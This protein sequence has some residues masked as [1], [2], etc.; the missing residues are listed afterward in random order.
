MGL[1]YPD[2]ELRSHA[3][4]QLHSRFNLFLISGFVLR[5]RQDSLWTQCKHGVG[6][7][8]LIGVN[9]FSFSVHGEF[10]TETFVE[11][12]NDS[13]LAT[14]GITDMNFLNPLI[15]SI[16]NIQEVF[17]LVFNAR[18]VLFMRCT[19]YRYIYTCISYLPSIYR[20]TLTQG[21]KMGGSCVCS[22]IAFPISYK[23]FIFN[24]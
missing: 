19:Q 17:V 2:L 22:T 3:P 14:K 12:R 10:N 7:A 9:L 5:L 23:Y 16:G 20:W 8:T 24:I 4:N 6:M 15:L 1:T 21:Q 18:V 11:S 13:Y